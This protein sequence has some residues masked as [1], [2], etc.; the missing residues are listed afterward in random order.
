MHDHGSRV[1]LSYETFRD[2]RYHHV[3]LATFGLPPSCPTEPISLIDIGRLLGFSTVQAE[4]ALE[5]AFPE[6]G[7][8][9]VFF[10][11]VKL[12]WSGQVDM[13]DELLAQVFAG[14]RKHEPWPKA[15]GPC[16]Q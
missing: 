6:P 14:L 7:T 10:T 16:T 8:W 4:P 11:T 12:R 1:S 2:E 5:F 3:P 9:P 13:D 15:A